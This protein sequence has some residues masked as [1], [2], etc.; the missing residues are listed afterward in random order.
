MIYS[1]AR[2]LP[3]SDLTHIYRYHRASADQLAQLRAAYAQA[4]TT[5]EQASA[6]LA[7][8]GHENFDTCPEFSSRRNVDTARSTLAGRG[9]TSHFGWQNRREDRS[10]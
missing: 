8:L 10:D 6:T 9:L 2:L 3:E 4:I 1:P 5:T 7:F